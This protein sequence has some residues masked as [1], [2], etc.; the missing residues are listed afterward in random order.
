M[1][2]RNAPGWCLIPISLPAVADA[3]MLSKEENNQVLIIVGGSFLSAEVEDR[4]GEEERL[5]IDN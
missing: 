2:G 3:T 1:H 5:V 4:R